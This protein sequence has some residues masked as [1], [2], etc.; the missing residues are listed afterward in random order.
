MKLRRWMLYTGECLHFHTS[1]PDFSIVATL[2]DFVANPGKLLRQVEALLGYSLHEPNFK[3][4]YKPDLLTR[5][6]T[7]LKTFALPRE[8][9]GAL[10]MYKKA[11]KLSRTWVL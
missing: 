3:E 4:L 10:L 6:G 8:Y 7:W 2:E 9:F 5:K 1:N 11:L